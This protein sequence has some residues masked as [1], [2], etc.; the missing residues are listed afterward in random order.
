MWGTKGT[1]IYIG[2][3]IFPIPFHVVYLFLV[4]EFHPFLNFTHKVSSH[5]LECFHFRVEWIKMDKIQLLVL[6][7]YKLFNDNT[8][9]YPSIHPF[10]VACSL[11]QGTRQETAWTGSQSITGLTPFSHY[12]QL[13]D[14]SQLQKLEYLEKSCKLKPPTSEVLSKHANR[15]EK[16]L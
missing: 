9:F 13:T 6:L 12:W 16:Y 14:A 8:C 4:L 1:Y 11:S 10:S 7:K 15:W 2:P 5:E 3:D